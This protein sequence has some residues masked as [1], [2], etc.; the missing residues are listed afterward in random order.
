MWTA[1]ASKQEV[2]CKGQTARKLMESR[3]SRED[4]VGVGTS[5]PRNEKV[6]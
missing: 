1:G 5:A 6:G 4:R 3:G 2:A